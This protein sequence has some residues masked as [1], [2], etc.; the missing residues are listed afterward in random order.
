MVFLALK[1]DIK[2]KLLVKIASLIFVALV[3]YSLWSFSHTP[4]RERSENDFNK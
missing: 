4:T 1:V 2:G 3:G